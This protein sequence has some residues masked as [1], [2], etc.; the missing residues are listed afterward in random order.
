MG[1]FRTDPANPHCVHPDD[2]LRVDRQVLLN[3]PVA[4][5]GP[6]ER[7][8][9]HVTALESYGYRCPAF[10]CAEWESEAAMHRSI[11]GRLEFP[12]Y[13][14]HNL[15]ALNDC[16]GYLDIPEPGGVAL[17][18]WR[19]DRFVRLSAER[20]WEVLD[21]IASASW[22]HRLYGRRLMGL[23]QSDDPELHFAPVGARPVMWVSWECHKPAEPVAAP[24]RRGV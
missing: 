6:A 23:V 19:F 10:D 21:V 14:G 7:L 18:L 4:M 1:S 8:H 13:Y 15:N 3:G 5:Y 11:A 24:D 9:Q 12:G 16:L 2:V 20:A 22:V 17:V